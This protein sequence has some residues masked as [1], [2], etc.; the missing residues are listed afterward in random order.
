[1]NSGNTGEDVFPGDNGAVNEH[2]LSPFVSP[3][4]RGPRKSLPPG[5]SPLFVN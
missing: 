4:A 2:G 1:M 5:N 3:A